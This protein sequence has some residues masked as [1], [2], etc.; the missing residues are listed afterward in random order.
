M[1]LKTSSLQCGPGDPWDPWSLFM[2][3]TDRNN[4]CNN[5]HY[6]TF[7]YAFFFKKNLFLHVHIAM[8]I[9]LFLAVLGLPCMQAFSSCREWGLL[10]SCAPRASGCRGPLAAEH[11]LQ[12]TRAS[13]AEIPR[14]QSTG[15]IVV[16]PRLSCSVACGLFLDQGLEPVSPALAGNSYPLRHQGRPSCTVFHGYAVEFPRG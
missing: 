4:F 11:S 5:R 3:S 12:G 7:S 1:A 13:E 2:E 10:P 8:F 6:L 14:L 15:L 16:A 9:Y